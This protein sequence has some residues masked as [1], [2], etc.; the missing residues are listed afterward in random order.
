MLS[1]P[2][3]MRCASLVGLLLS[4]PAAAQAPPAWNGR[5][6]EDDGVVQIWNPAVPLQPPREYT[7]TPL[8]SSGADPR[9]ELFGRLADVAVTADGSSYLLD[10]QMNRV[11]IYDQQGRLQAEIG[12]QGEGP[13][14]MRRPGAVLDLGPGLVGIAD[15]SPG[16]V[17][18]LQTSGI[19]AGD[20]PL[21]P[22]A[23]EGTRLFLQAAASGADRIVLEVRTGRRGGGE[24]VGIVQLLAIDF[25]GALLCRYLQREWTIDPAHP[26][27]SDR[28]ETF[29]RGHWAIL[30]DGHLYVV[31][32]RDAFHLGGYAADGR[33]VREIRRAGAASVPHDP[34]DLERRTAR[35]RTGGRRGQRHGGIEI[36]L[37]PNRPEILALWAGPTGELWVRTASHDKQ[38]PRGA[39][40]ILEVF[41]SEGRFLCEAHIFDPDPLPPDDCHYIGDRLY[42]FESSGDMPPGT[43]EEPGDWNLSDADTPLSRVTCYRLVPR[44]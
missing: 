25:R 22:V 43:D 30:P 34:A 16:R 32:E 1:P 17:I 27:I 10:E 15:F 14:E 31:R 4:L 9:D 3:A 24:I 44:R 18:R 36:D 35:V 23:P 26:R 28:G 37:A 12:R 41:D 2:H 7:L 29:D 33:L 5:I 13:G 40:E 20:I 21:E 8:W 11:R 38:L 42:R 6:T 39:Q 19:P